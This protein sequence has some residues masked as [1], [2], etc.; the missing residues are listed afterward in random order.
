MAAIPSIASPPRQ[1]VTAVATIGPFAA[2]AAIASATRHTVTTVAP[3]TTGV[4]IPAASCLAAE[5]TASTPSGLAA[6]MGQRRK[7]SG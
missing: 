6:S 5:A 4:P 7:D 1:A 3:F 2:I